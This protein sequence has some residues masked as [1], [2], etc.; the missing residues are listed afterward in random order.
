MIRCVVHCRND[1]L[2]D[3]VERQKILRKSRVDSTHLPH[4]HTRWHNK[5]VSSVAT[6]Q[7]ADVT[8]IGRGLI[9]FL[10]LPARRYVE[11]TTHVG[12]FRRRAER[13]VTSAAAADADA[14]EWRR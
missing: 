8:V 6:M 7:L 3:V 2:S 10:S 9:S 14:N 1:G 11:I 5:Y 4:S 13:D 12:Y